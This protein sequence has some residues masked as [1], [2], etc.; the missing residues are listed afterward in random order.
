MKRIFICLFLL[1]AALAPAQTTTQDGALVT[2]VIGKRR[3]A[4]ITSV[5]A[6]GS[7]AAGAKS[8]TFIFSLDFT[9]TVAG[10]AFTGAAD[11]SITITAPGADTLSA[12]AYTVT[13]G[14]IR[15]VEV[16]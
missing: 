1:C 7:V 2:T 10:G 14:S 12:V 8:I 4:S 11:T 13:A 15:I 6:S 16:Q 3:T 5:N 9:G